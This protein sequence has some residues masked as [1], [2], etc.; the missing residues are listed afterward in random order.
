MLSL[1]KVAKPSRLL[2]KRGISFSSNVKI[3]TVIG[4]VEMRK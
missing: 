3:P 2:A 4:V 1:G